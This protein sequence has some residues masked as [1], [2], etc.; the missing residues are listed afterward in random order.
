M[1]RKSCEISTRAGAESTETSREA[2][3]FRT[4]SGITHSWLDQTERQ[5][6]HISSEKEIKDYCTSQSNFKFQSLGIEQIGS[7]FATRTK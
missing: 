6:Q 5:K 3:C 4:R 2:Y 1:P 7:F